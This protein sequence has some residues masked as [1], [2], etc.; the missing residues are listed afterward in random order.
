CRALRWLNSQN[1]QWLFW[2]AETSSVNGRS[3]CSMFRVWSTADSMLFLLPST[4]WKPTLV[5]QLHATA[6]PFST[7]VKKN[8]FFF[9]KTACVITDNNLTEVDVVDRLSEILEKTCDA[10][11]VLSAQREQLDKFWADREG[12][13]HNF[14]QAQLEDLQT[15]ESDS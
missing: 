2:I 15:C 1:Q 10:L 7:I 13:D 9:C 12:Q 11:K 14:R 6:K 3:V 5:Q 4:T 8:V